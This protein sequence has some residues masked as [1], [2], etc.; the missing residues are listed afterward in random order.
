[1]AATHPTTAAVTGIAS[2]GSTSA[3]THGTPTPGAKAA[4][5]ICS[6][7]AAALLAALVYFFVNKRRSSR[8]ARPHQ[9]Q[10]S[11]GGGG[12]VD[13]GGRGSSGG[14]M[15]TVSD[16]H[17]D[18]AEFGEFSELGEYGECGE[19]G[20][21]GGRGERGNPSTISLKTR[22]RQSRMLFL[23]GHLRGA[24]ARNSR[25]PRQPGGEVPTPLIS[26]ANSCSSVPGVINS[27]GPTSLQKFQLDGGDDAQR[28]GRSLWSFVLSPSLFS[29]RDRQDRSVSPP[30]TSLSPPPSPTQ[31]SARG[32][33]TEQA[34]SGRIDGNNAGFYSYSSSPVPYYFPSSPICAPTTNKL[35][36]RRERTP[37]MKPNKSAAAAPLTAAAAKPKPPQALGYYNFQGS[38]Q[39][40]YSQP[41][42]HSAAESAG[43]AG[44]ARGLRSSYGSYSTATN[45]SIPASSLYGNAL[46]SNMMEPMTPVP[47]LPAPPSPASPARPPRPHES[48]LEIPDLV[49]PDPPPLPPPPRGTRASASASASRSFS[50]P[51]S[52]FSF[53][54]LGG[55][56]NLSGSHPPPPP[57][58]VPPAMTLS[59]PAPLPA[60]M[61]DIVY[62]NSLDSFSSHP[63]AIANAK[64][65]LSRMNPKDPILPAGP[66]PNRA[67]P[68]PPPP[69]PV[70][71]MSSKRLSGTA[72]LASMARSLSL[73]PQPPP[74]QTVPEDGE[75]IASFELPPLLM[76]DDPDDGPWAGK[77]AK[78]GLLS[79][80]PPPQDGSAPS[81]AQTSSFS[82][83]MSA[84]SMLSSSTADTMASMTT[85]STMATR[86]MTA[87]AAPVLAVPGSTPLAAEPSAVATL[88]YKTMS[89]ASSSLTIKPE[90]VVE[91]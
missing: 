52:A 68:S 59:A 32:S 43:T 8:G 60:P 64:A 10:G 11:M 45:A 27:A 74:P 61:H 58:R 30:L 34:G 18:A 51:A 3:A 91:S 78:P 65:G 88:F 90:K 22:L 13:G 17:A 14:E 49:M 47:G 7:L 19:Y 54:S 84:S 56:K 38:H 31:L 29:R 46:T 75:S 1:M 67:L 36:P 42:R 5:A 15:G 69:P 40:S 37:T 63:A 79:S 57:P 66:P 76:R 70:P 2:S 80:R 83:T 48:P 24:A 87:T 20:G 4:I 9:H 82:S 28:S 41:D 81:K 50:M 77:T 71:P 62:A 55:R 6:V 16:A 35:E 86:S 25:H 72:S 33:G 73:S 53:S 85:S 89:T 26:P 12:M 39:L 23:P 21:R 44:S